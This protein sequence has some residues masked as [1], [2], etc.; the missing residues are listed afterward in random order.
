M[1]SVN[2]QLISFENVNLEFK[3]RVGFLATEQY[4]ALQDINFTLYKGE[5]LG[6][7]GDNGAGKSSLLKLL[8]GTLLPTSGA[9]IKNGKVTC[10]LLSLQ[11]ASFQDLTGY[12]NMIMHG[13][14]LGHS[15]EE[16][17]ERIDEILA[18]AEVGD[19]I[20]KPIRTYSSGMIA[21]LKFATAITMQPDI[22]LVD[23]VL[24]VGDQGFRKK[25][26]SAMKN[27]IQ[28]DDQTVV[29]VSHSVPTIQELC[30]RVLWLEEGRIRRVGE[31][32]EV[33]NEYTSET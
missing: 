19:W 8:A 6:V 3:I 18:F 11:L 32:S 12:D 9:I 21:R 20:Y 26:T 15:K 7:V 28:S 2:D 14:M 27:K 23:E 30:T 5:I 33:L 31:S 24:G 16:V 10:S 4:V 13:I 22:M 17:A 25:S 1:A 29:L